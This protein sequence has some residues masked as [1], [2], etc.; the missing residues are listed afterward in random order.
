M[1]H[2]TMFEDN[3]PS[4]SEEEDF[5]T[6][7]TIFGHPCHLGLSGTFKPIFVPLLL[8]GALKFNRNWPSHFKENVFWSVKRPA[9]QVTSGQGPNWPSPLAFF[10]IHIVP[11]LMSQTIIIFQQEAHGPQFAHLH[12][13]KCHATVFQYCHSNWDTNLTI[14]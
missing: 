1:L 12:I 4:G 11:S 2:N 8:E 6:T 14:P 3:W 10:D 9:V 5:F 7:F 13:C